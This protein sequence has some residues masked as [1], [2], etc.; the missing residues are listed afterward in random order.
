MKAV[1]SFSKTDIPGKIL[2]INYG[3]ALF[4]IMVW[5]SFVLSALE[6][7]VA[8]KHWPRFGDPSPGYG[9]FHMLLCIL[10]MIYAMPV[11]FVGSIVLSIY[12]R[13]RSSGYPI[14]RLIS[15][16]FFSA[17]L[18]VCLYRIDPGGLWNWTWD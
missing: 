8:L 11:L 9:G 14:I 13:V 17:G 6:V 15:L 4:P 1:K 16:N 18:F 2:W 3:L 12:G 5:I 7:A 10:A